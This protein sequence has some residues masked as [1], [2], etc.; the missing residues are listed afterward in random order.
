MAS[1]VKSRNLAASSAEAGWSCRRT[2]ADGSLG[3]RDRPVSS[4]GRLCYSVF[5]RNLGDNVDAKIYFGGRGDAN[6]LADE[7]VD[8]DLFGRWG[9]GCEWIGKQ[10]AWQIMKNPTLYNV[11]VNSTTGAIRGQLRRS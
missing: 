4:K 7:R 2:T 8:L 3:R 1:N 5:T 11:Q 6:S 9:S 10:L